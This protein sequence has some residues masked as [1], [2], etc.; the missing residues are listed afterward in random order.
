[1]K[2]DRQTVKCLHKGHSVVMSP[3]R[4]QYM[5]LAIDRSA[6]QCVT[7]RQTDREKEGVPASECTVLSRFPGIGRHHRVKYHRDRG[8]EGVPGGQSEWCSACLQV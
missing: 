7:D 8:K 4:A 2:Y 5:V 6:P 1:M 3:Y